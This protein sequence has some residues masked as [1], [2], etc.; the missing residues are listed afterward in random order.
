LTQS[1]YLEFLGLKQAWRGALAAFGRPEPR[2][3]LKL[4]GTR[5]LEIHGI[6]GWVRHP[7]YISGL[8]YFMTSA[9][10]LNTF[11]FAFMYA[12]YMVV[13]THYEERRLIQIF[14]P[15]YLAY[16]G[17]VGAFAPRLWAAQPTL[18]GN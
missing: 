15:D 9:P 11:V 13:G 6:Y 2:S 1:D 8:I 4:F 5:R 14:G 12:L 7:M 18:E 3:A 16:R 17:R 10:S